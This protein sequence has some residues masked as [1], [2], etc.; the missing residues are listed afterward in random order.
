MKLAARRFFDALCGEYLLGTLQG[1]A[2]R[3][4]ERALREE[5]LAARRLRYWQGLFAPRYA[6]AIETKPAPAVWKRLERSLELERYRQPWFRRPGFWRAWAIAATAALVAVVGLQLVPRPEVVVPIAQL[7]GKDPAAGQVTAHLSKDGRTMVLHSA[8]PVIAGPAQ[9]Y[10]LWL[11]TP[12]GTALSLA[13][14]GS[15][16][17][18]FEVPEGHRRRV[19]QGGQLAVTVE[20]AGGSP[21]GRATGPVILVGPIKL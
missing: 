14:L 5:P 4:F 13:V 19:R 11:L 17:A 10:E 7:S 3:R 18:R 9:S 1:A 15:L 16:D 2:R 21:T 12:E 20:P 6:S 8:R